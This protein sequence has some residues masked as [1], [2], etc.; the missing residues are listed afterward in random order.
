MAKYKVSIDPDFRDLAPKYLEARRAELAELRA[1]LDKGELSGIKTA[2]HK[3]AGTGGG[4]G[5][6]HLSEIGRKMELSAAVGDTADLR[7]LLG[8]L[9]DYLSDL[10]IVYT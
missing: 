8:E 4:Y 9:E 1:M 2:G 7:A 3:L 5:F 10:E 6:E